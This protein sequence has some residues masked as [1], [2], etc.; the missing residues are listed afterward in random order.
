M[1][2]IGC[3]DSWAWGAEL[4]LNT[5]TIDEKMCDHN[6]HF[7]EANTNYRLN[8][9]YLNLFANKINASSIVDLSLAAYSNEGIYRSL[10]RYLAMEGYLSGKD[11]S[12]L[13][14]SIGWSSPE[15]R[16]FHCQNLDQFN[17]FVPTELN[18]Y[19]SQPEKWVTLGPW[20]AD[21]SYENKEIN[22]FFE[23]Y[24]K[25]FWTDLEL[26]YRWVSII[27]NT[28]TLLKRHNIKYVMHQAFFHYRTSSLRQWND[29]K[30]EQDIVNNWTVFER[31][32]FKSIDN[33][34]FVDKDI[35]LKT[36][37]EYVLEK[38][39]GDHDKVFT[40]FHPN[41]YGHQL[42]ADHLYNFCVGNNLLC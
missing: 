42:Y 33:K 25:Y 3:G 2:L 34:H 1:K 21:V 14:V 35:F 38:A 18:F 6:E 30:Y 11:T 31:E 40:V 19:S 39:N 16:E 27:K 24:F 4:T 28:E 36:F 23:L 20:Y 37:H 22:K 7:N 13:F 15:R 17:G 8:N 9:R 5:N 29:K 41:E 26:M 12:D 32:I 10:L